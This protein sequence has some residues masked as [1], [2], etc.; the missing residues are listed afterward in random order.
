A[1]SKLP[2]KLGQPMVRPSAK[3]VSKVDLDESKAVVSSGGAAIQ[4]GVNG[5]RE[6]VNISSDSSD[7][8][9]DYDAD[10]DNEDEDGKE[11]HQN[12]VTDTT[13]EDAAP[14]FRDAQE[15][16][17]PS[18][19][20]LVRASIA[21]P[22]DVAGAFNDP[23]SLAL[24]YPQRSQ[25]QAPSGASLG[26]VLTQALKTNDIALLES[27]LHTTDH[28]TIRATIQRLE[29]PLA[30]TLLNKLAERLHRRPGRA[31]S[32]LVW[33]QWTMVT[34]GGYLATQSDLIKR[35]AELNRVIEERSKSL[36]SL[37][38]L[39]GKLD[40]LEAQM[41]LR[42]SMQAS[43]R[44]DEDDEEGV[45]YVEGQESEEESDVQQ[46][47][48]RGG[49]TE[50]ISEDESEISEDMPTRNGVVA[51]SEDSDIDSSDG[52]N[53][54]DDEAEESDAESGD[55]DS[56]DHDEIDSDAEDDD[57]DDGRGAR[58]TKIQKTGGPFSK[59][60]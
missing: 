23:S 48:I 38:S 36:P 5:V 32:L 7:A 49:D 56:V 29:S 33:V 59:K 34:H 41:E 58:P 40:M 52:D 18:F 50:N 30:G 25:I 24:Q 51:D 27:C 31:G 60:R 14:P 54:I 6:I 39:K 44:D 26:T 12:G 13:M 2:T 15:A 45:I 22:I 42:K 21:E 3:A 11:P 19:G 17:E 16:A 1:M 43:Q 20:D 9:D 55:E 10:S 8:E 57:S 28:N 53:L 37:L 47:L 35:L 46:R 4:L